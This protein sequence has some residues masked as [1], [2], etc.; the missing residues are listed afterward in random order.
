MIEVARVEE[1]IDLITDDEEDE[2][3]K[4][5]ENT[6]TVETVSVIDFVGKVDV[7]K[8]VLTSNSIH[9]E[10]DSRTVPEKVDNESDGNEM[11][12][13]PITTEIVQS[14]NSSNEEIDVVSHFDDTL[15]LDEMNI[16][17]AA[18]VDEEKLSRDT[19]NIS[20]ESKPAEEDPKV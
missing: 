6:K 8:I 13:D 3:Q 12:V 18:E 14:G 19:F 9:T 15:K 10:N 20:L 16:T 4:E 2:S 11:Q 17:S 7:N 1:P 5:K